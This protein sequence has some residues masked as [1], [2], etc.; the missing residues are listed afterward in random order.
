M[1][2]DSDLVNILKLMDANVTK[3]VLKFTNICKIYCMFKS[4]WIF[5][6]ILNNKFAWC[7]M[8]FLYQ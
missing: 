1:V 4:M 3:S 2:S 5:L 8:Y 7:F 6:N